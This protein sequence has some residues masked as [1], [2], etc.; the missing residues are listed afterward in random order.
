MQ[1]EIAV[2]RLAKFWFVSTAVKVAAFLILIAVV[3]KL[4][5]GF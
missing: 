2:R 5:G 1:P 4:F 3:V